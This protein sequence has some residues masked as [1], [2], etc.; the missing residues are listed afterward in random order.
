MLQSASVAD[1]LIGFSGPAGGDIT[2]LTG[3]LQEP[4]VCKYICVQVLIFTA[5]AQRNIK[6]Y[7]EAGI[8]KLKISNNLERQLKRARSKHGQLWMILQGIAEANP[9]CSQEIQRALMHYMYATASDENVSSNMQVTDAA[10]ERQ[11]EATDD[12]AVS[13]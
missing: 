13:T 6:L 10:A 5:R 9:E 8:G 12:G 11:N 4:G 2:L 7:K 3:A 1:N